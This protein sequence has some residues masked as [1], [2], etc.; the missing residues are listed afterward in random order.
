MRDGIRV[1]VY[2]SLKRGF[3]NHRLLEGATFVEEDRVPGYAL[4]SGEGAYF[5]FAVD[6]EPEF[7]VCGEVYELSGKPQLAMLDRLEGH[8]N[9]YKRTAVRSDSGAVMWMYVYQGS[10]KNLDLFNLETWTLEGETR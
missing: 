4:M 6:A 1:F 5:P 7:G 2:G 10:T 3:Q 8:P 9:F